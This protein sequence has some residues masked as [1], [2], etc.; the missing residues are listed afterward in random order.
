VSRDDDWDPRTVA[1]RPA[2]TVMLL[3]DGDDDTA[4]PGLEVFML[5]RTRGAAFAGGLYVFPGGRVDEADGEGEVG[6]RTAAIRECF[7]EA[8]VLLAVDGG[9]RTVPDGHPALALRHA[10]HDGEVSLEEV[11]RRHGLRPALDELHWVSHWVT[12][13]GEARRFDT[14]FYAAR[15]PSGQQSRH[16]DSETVASEWVRPAAWV[17]RFAARE[18]NLM[19]PTIVSLRFLAGFDDTAAALAAVDAQSTPE[20][21]HP[22]VRFGENWAIEAV[23]LPG[24]PGYDELDP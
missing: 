7:E 17:A 12:P 14:R 23:L 6:F 22:R 1:I 11:C 10:V 4:G 9:G 16:D 5:R 8:G 18:L 21:I 19:P 24:D 15:V 20:P 3:R 2:S 13:M